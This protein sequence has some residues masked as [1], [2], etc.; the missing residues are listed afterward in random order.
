MLFATCSRGCGR[1]RDVPLHSAISQTLQ[2]HALLQAKNINKT[3]LF[4]L[5]TQII[6]IELSF[7]SSP[8]CE[9]EAYRSMKHETEVEG[10]GM[11]REA[12][13]FS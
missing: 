4:P 11:C 5:Q 9:G 3:L 6:V 8:G 7:C 10:I 12:G 1:T 13:G 2:L